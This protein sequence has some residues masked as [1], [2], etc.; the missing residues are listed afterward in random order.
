MHV[1][2]PHKPYGFKSDCS[3]DNK[4]S[5]LNYFFSKENHFKQHNIERVCVINYLD[6]FLSKFKSLDDMKIIIISDHGSRISNDKRSSLSNLI[7]YK[8]FNNKNS[9]LIKEE[10]K[11]QKIFKNFFK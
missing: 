3:Y 2:V 5:N 9:K 4:L 6:N 10:V 7:S 11:M 1:L 8:D